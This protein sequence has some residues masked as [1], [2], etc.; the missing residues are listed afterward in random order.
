VGYWEWGSKRC[1]RV[2]FRICG[3]CIN[4][5]RVAR[6]GALGGVRLFAGLASGLLGVGS[7]L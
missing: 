6:E 2:L 5:L 4:G 7:A 1:G 3:V